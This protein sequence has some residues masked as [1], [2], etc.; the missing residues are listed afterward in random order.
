MTL[1]RGLFQSA[2]QHAA[3][4]ARVSGGDLV[5]SLVEKKIIRFIIAVDR[6]GRES[7]IVFSLVYLVMLG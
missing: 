7:L 2:L 6:E 1:Q 4:A 5:Y 3:R